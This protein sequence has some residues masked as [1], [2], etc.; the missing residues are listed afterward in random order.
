MHTVLQRRRH[1]SIKRD[2]FT[3]IEL[4]IVIA[5]TAILAA[6]ILPALASA[7]ERSRRAACKS[8][9]HQLYLGCAMFA[10]DNG[11]T[12]PTAVN[13]HGYSSTMILSD[14]TYNS[15]LN[16]VGDQRVFYGYSST[17]ILS[18]STYNSILNYVGDQRVFYCPNIILGNEPRHSDDK[19]YQIG[20]NY[21]GN[22]DAAAASEKGV[23]TWI[24]A[25]KMTDA[26]TNYLLAD[27]NF[28]GGQD[29]LKLAPHTIS[30]AALA[31]NSSF[32]RNLPGRTSADLG[33]VGGN[34]C[35]LDGSINW[36]SIG[37]MHTFHA[38]TEPTYFGNW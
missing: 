21:L 26:G 5:I 28:W 27:A 4:G 23:D 19:G 36:K 22:V 37:A 1:G 12:L 20:Y 15:I 7:K 13:N 10:D 29:K 2:G 32:T 9:E 25:K 3:L 35:T 31:N 34:V 24:S 38:T 14:S 11:Q 16:Y 33:A 30:G 18:D 6:L 17:M 8:N